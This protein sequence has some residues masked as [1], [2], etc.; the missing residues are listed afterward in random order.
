MRDMFM[1]LFSCGIVIV[2]FLGTAIHAARPSLPPF[3]SPPGEK[4]ILVDPRIHA[5][6]A[7]TAD[8]TLVRSGLASAGKNWCPDIKRPC[9]TQTG[10]FRIYYLGD[11]S[12]ISTRFPIP[13]GG[14]PMP[15]CMYFNGNQ[16]LH[17]SYELGYANLSHG[18]VRMRVSDAKW[19]R[20]QFIDQPNDSNNYS[21]TL[22]VIQP[23]N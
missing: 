10:T 15:Y 17:G 18:C 22:V 20:Y 13:N 1:K 9:R 7:Y 8:G 5:W 3:I 2:S 16:A 11:S 14:A 12:C 6:G 21:G 19:L 4:M 23:Y